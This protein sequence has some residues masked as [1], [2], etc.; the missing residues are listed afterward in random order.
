VSA[1]GQ[2]GCR[3]QVD[4][5]GSALKF[6]VQGY[7]VWR[8]RSLSYRVGRREGRSPSSEGSLLTSSEINMK[9]YDDDLRNF[10]AHGA[11]PLS[12]ANNKSHVDHDGARIWYATYGAGSPV[13]L[14][15]GGLGHSGNWV[16]RFQCWWA[17]AIA[18]CLSTAARPRPQYTR[19]AA[20]YV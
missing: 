11:A 6:I 13:I 10:E 16:I 17:L 7:R 1:L 20:V 9:S 15:H 2:G 14:L 19:F 8:Q 12:A 4:G 5:G 18:P 3:R